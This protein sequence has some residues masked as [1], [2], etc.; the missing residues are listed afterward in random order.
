MGIL[1]GII[2]DGTSGALVE[3]KVNVLSSNGRFVHPSN[4]LLKVGPGDPFFYS[5]GEF[6][7]N[8]PRGATDIVVERGTEYQPLRNVVSMPQKGEV[9]VE[10][11]L[12]RWIDLPSQNWYPVNTHLH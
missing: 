2:R 5:S 1:R 10:L 3:A 6:T 7:V 4:S 12:K 9:E 8:L 11:N